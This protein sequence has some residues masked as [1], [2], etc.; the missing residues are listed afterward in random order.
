LNLS[1]H[2]G[3]LDSSTKGRLTSNG[4]YGKQIMNLF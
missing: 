1:F 2:W 3:N 4:F